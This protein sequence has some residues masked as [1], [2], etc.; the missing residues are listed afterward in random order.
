[1]HLA[2]G[3]ISHG[4]AGQRHGQV[5]GGDLEQG[6]AQLDLPAIEDGRSDKGVALAVRLDLAGFRRASKRTA[7]ARSAQQRRARF[8]GRLDQR[9][10]CGRVGGGGIGKILKQNTGVQLQPL[11]GFRAQ[12]GGVFLCHR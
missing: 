5:A 12:A 4:R 11:E 6:G 2:A 1:M 3:I 9:S 8:L 10:Q 7:S